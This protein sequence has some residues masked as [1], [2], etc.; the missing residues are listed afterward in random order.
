MALSLSLIITAAGA[1]LRYA[2]TPT[3]SHGFR[4]GTVGAILMIVGIVGAVLSIIEWGTRSYRHSRTTATTEAGGHV[5][6]REDV[7][8]RGLV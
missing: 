8:Q 7:E 2:Y 6:R 1:V 3:A 4:W 5:V